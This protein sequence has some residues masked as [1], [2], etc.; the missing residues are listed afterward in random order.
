MDNDTSMTPA[1]ALILAAAAFALMPAAGSAQVGQDTLRRDTV[2]EIEPIAVRAIRPVTTTGGVSAITVRLD[3]VRFRAVPLL[4]DVMREIPLVQVRTNSRG[5]AQLALR[6]ADERQVA[7]LLDGIPLTLGWD[8]RTDLSVIPLTAAQSIRLVR[9]LSSVLHGPNVLGG[10]VEIG[11]GTAGGTTPEP[12]R[13][14]AGV[15]DNGGRA[16]GVVAGAGTDLGDDRLVVRA[17]AGHRSQDGYAAPDDPASVYPALVGGDLRANSDVAHYD[18]FVSARYDDAGDS[19]ISA[20]LTGFTAER[21]VPPELSEAGPRLWRYPEVSRLVG[22]LAA[23]SDLDGWGGDTRLDVS[24]GLDLGRTEIED[25]LL[26]ATPSDPTLEPAA[27][28]SALNEREYSEDRT[29]TARVVSTT[30]VTERTQLRVAGTFGDVFHEEIITTGLA[31]TPEFFPAE[32]NQRLWSLGVEMDTEIVLEDA[33][34][35]GGRLSAGL[36][37]DGADTPET[38]DPAIEGRT[39]S[40]W[41]GRIGA[42][43]TTTGGGLLLHAGLSRRGRFPALREMYSTALGRFEPN[44]DL[45]PEILTSVETGFTT[46]RGGFDLQLVGFHQNLDD[47]IV[48]GAPPA[49]SDARYQRVNRDAIRSTGLELLA[50][51]NT[52]RF[53]LETELTL[54]DVEAVAPGSAGVRAEY[55]PELVAG[56]GA[57]LPLVAGIEAAAEV[58]YMGRQYCST[59]APGAEDYATLDASTRADVQLARS[60]RLERRVASFDRVGVELAVDNATDALTY[61][62]CGLPRPGRTLRLQVRLN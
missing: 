47:A 27:F 32:Y 41:G 23:S 21:G 11:M 50:G 22:V 3:S 10:V 9:G 30:P 14:Q 28:F 26:P 45:R 36:A 2:Y 44:P 13:L 53:A 43:A 56:I 59:P 33:P 8:H 54:Q 20:S 42:S 62:Q 31:A 18:G 34:L 52:G 60:F 46:R 38:G 57:S 19:W 5:Q 25:F 49:G 7:I 12:L 48:R 24:L 51:Y 40:E 61:D 1:V 29:V 15:D 58:E 55:E 16:L 37:Y 17:G 6:G 39:M 4:E 35:G